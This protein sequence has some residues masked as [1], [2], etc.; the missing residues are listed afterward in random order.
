MALPVAPWAIPCAPLAFLCRSAR[1]VSG[2]AP[3]WSR[4]FYFS[5]RLKTNHL[6]FAALSGHCSGSHSAAA[7]PTAD[8]GEFSG[9]RSPVRPPASATQLEPF[10]S[11]GPQVQIPP[12]RDP[13]VRSPDARERNARAPT[14]G[15]PRL[16]AWSQQPSSHWHR[17]HRRCNPILHV[18]SAPPTTLGGSRLPQVRRAYPQRRRRDSRGRRRG[19]APL[20]RHRRDAPK[21]KRT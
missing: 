8:T 12:L 5:A 14:L 1:R 4:F 3:V 2:M 11:H 7:S 15:G 17:Q 18:R 9:M 19:P 13:S 16:I 10:F 20:L 6:Y 21:D